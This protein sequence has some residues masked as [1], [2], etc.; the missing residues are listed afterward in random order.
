MALNPDIAAYLKLVDNG[1]SS[2]KNLPMHLLTVQQAREQFDQ[3]ST[4]MD[5]GVDAR[6]TTVES[7]TITARDDTPLAVRL[8]RPLEMSGAQPLPGLLYLHGG[9]YVVG[10][11]DSHD[12]LCA[13]LAER[14]GCLVISLAYRLAP[15]W[16][17]PTAVEDGEDA[18]HWLVAESARLGIDPQR[19]AL[20]GDSVGGS[21]CAALSREL[22]LRDVVSQPRLQVLIYPVTDASRPRDSIERYGVG[23][24]LEKDS[25]EWFYQQYQRTAEDRQDPRFS[26]L[27]GAV[28][29]GLAPTLLIVAE[30]DPLHDEG[31]AYAEHLQRGGAQVE[32][33]LYSGM[34]HDFLRMGALVDEADDA[35]D[36]IAERL[37][38]ALA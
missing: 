20:A 32:L 7:L 10:S 24:L 5:P 1:R 31:L 28:P 3:S 14:A 27:L 12:T 36:L 2:G 38:A 17:F 23:H 26:P 25:L 9:G 11:L 21:L 34:T 37:I 13:S 6:K 19:L 8:Y 35:K 33:S 16:R 29:A 15:E 4:L 22:A 18:W 30:C